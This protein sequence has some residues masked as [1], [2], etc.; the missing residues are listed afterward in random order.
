MTSSMAAAASSQSDQPRSAVTV[1]AD[2]AVSS[3][4]A[5]HSCQHGTAV[6]GTVQGLWLYP[7]KSCAAV[8]VAHWPLGKCGL[9]WDREWALVDEHGKVLTQKKLPRLA[10]IKPQIDLDRGVM[11]LSAPGVEQPLVVL[12]VEGVILHPR[13]SVVSSCR[14]NSSETAGSNYVEVTVCTDTLCGTQV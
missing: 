8:T 6:T 1:C 2:T 11:Q 14:H 13:D 12:L 9:M 5:V 3:S 4:P 10:L 7:V